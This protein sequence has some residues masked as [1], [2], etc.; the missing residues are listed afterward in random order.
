MVVKRGQEQSKGLSFFLSLGPA[1][2]C[3]RGRGK[4]VC[5]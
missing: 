1:E 4:V 2:R 5:R 3:G